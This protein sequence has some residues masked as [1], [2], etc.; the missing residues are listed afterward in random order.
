MAVGDTALFA[1][2]SYVAIG[3]EST[4]GT[5]VTASAGLD[6]LSTSIRTVKDAKILEEISRKR[7]HQRDFRMGKVVE[8]EIQSYVY[9]DLT[10]LGYLLQNAFGGAV[11]TA[12]AT[13][14]TTG[15]SALT[16]TFE[17]GSYTLT[18]TGLTVNIRKG[19]S[20]GGKVEEF[21]GGRINTLSLVAEID[22]PLV[23]TVGL[24][25]KD[26][27]IGATD[28]ESLLTATAIEPLSFVSGRLSVESTFASLTSTSFWHIQSLNFTMN[29]NLKTDGQARRIGTDTLARLPYGVQGYELSCVMR[30]DTT[31]AYS[32][33]QNSTEYCAE[34]E[35]LGS[36]ISGSAARRGLKVQFQKVTIKDAGDPEIGGPDETLEATV[37]FNV[38]RDE[39]ASGY[40]VRGLLTN[41]ISSF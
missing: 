35:F 28:V 3:R 4:W 6:F 8:G 9:P 29:N 26:S 30:F 24:A 21:V 39:S 19:P 32:A 18:H 14:E 40:A 15:G 12:T 20:S 11:T 22:E 5:G 1:G 2:E 37:V 7:T 31:T 13:G 38:L 16:H 10:A 23:M 25:F 27:T 36:T 34:F 17:T 33:M 41:N